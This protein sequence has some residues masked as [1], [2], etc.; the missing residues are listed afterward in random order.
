MYRLGGALVAPAERRAALEFEVK[1]QRAAKTLR[2][3]EMQARRLTQYMRSHHPHGVLGVDSTANAESAVYGAAAVGMK[4]FRDH[5][6]SHS[7]RR[8]A[9]QS[10]ILVATDRHGYDP[11]VHDPTYRADI[12]F[13]QQ[14][15]SHAPYADTNARIFQKRD[16]FANP[17][18]RQSLRDQDISGKDYDVITHTKVQLYPSTKP[19]RVNKILA[20]PSQQSS[21]R[22]RNVQGSLG[23]TP[24]L[25]G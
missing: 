12:H 5:R 21:E 4:D 2:S 10:K 25:L 6:A 14:K 15:A 3:A 8:R 1:R 11:F 19:V 23:G 17:T 7:E 9:N 16:H 18:R 24:C 20:H 13:M 22:G